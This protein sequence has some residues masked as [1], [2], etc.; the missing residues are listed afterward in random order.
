M[1]PLDF[2]EVR[3]FVNENIVD[4]HQRRIRT[5]VNNRIED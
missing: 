4:F 3:T 1:K 2:N 5:L